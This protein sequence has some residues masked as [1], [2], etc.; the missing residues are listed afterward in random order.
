MNKKETPIK[1]EGINDNIYA[2]FL[3][4]FASLILD[5][6]IM[7]PFIFFVLYLQYYIN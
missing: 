7:V 6:I 2:G 5:G 4:R 3:P 1:L